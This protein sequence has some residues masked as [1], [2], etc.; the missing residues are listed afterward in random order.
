MLHHS[1]PVGHRRRKNDDDARLQGAGDDIVG[2][3]LR[4]GREQQPKRRSLMARDVDRDETL[5][6]AAAIAAATHLPVTADTEDGY[7]DTPEGVAETVR[8]AAEAG[9]AGLSIEDR[10]P[11]AAKPIRDFDE[12][13]RAWPPRWKPQ[14]STTSPSPRAPTGWVRKPMAWTRPFAG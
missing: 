12:P 5:Q 10:Q 9:L 1:Q 3:R 6:Y 4:E 2:L 14:G 11:N 8:L 7:A 13:S